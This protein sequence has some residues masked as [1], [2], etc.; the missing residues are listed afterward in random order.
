[1][2][3][4][5]EIRSD[6]GGYDLHNRFVFSTAV[7]ASP[8]AAA[9][10][11]IAQLTV[12]EPEQVISGIWLGG[13]AAFTV[14]TSGTAVQLRIRRTSVGGALVV[15]TGALTAGIVAAALGAQD[16]EGVDT[17]PTLPGQIYCLTMQ[18]TAGAAT[19]TVSA[20]SLKAI[21]I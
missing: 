6:S 11:I 21:V 14:G 10:T 7:V 2:S 5:D 18:V 4:L 8:A 17:G 1:M 16:V 19:S 12:A 15:A 20:V 13:F 9:E 3:T